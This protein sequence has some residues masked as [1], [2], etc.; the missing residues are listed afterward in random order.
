MHRGA[1]G[2]LGSPTTTR[3][4]AAKGTGGAELWAKLTYSLHTQPGAGLRMMAFLHDRTSARSGASGTKLRVTKFGG[5]P[6]R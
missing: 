2:L 1:C 5:P 4:W 6:A 3:E